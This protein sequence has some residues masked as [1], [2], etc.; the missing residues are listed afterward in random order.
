MKQLERADSSVDYIKLLAE[1]SRRAGVAAYTDA[2]IREFGDLV[3]SGIKESATS[4]HRIR[5]LRAEALFMAVVAGIGKVQLIK[6]EDTGDVCYNG[7]DIRVPDF[8]IV[9]ADSCQMFVEVKV[10]HVDDVLRSQFRLSDSYV[11]ALGRYCELAGCDLKIA[12]F[13]EELRLWTLNR[14]E[15]FNPGIA[16]EKRWEISLPKALATSEMASLGDVTVATLAPIRFRVILD[17]ARSETIPPGT[18]GEFNAT[19]SAVQLLSQERLL[20]GT[21]AQIAWKLIW[22]GK[23]DE[24]GDRPHYEEGRLARVDHLL[25]P[26]EWAE[27]SAPDMDPHPVGALSEMISN[28]YLRGATNT[29]HTTAKGDVLTPGYMGN[30][31]PDN[32]VS[33]K[34]DLPLYMFR[35]VPNFEFAEGVPD[36]PAGKAG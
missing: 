9:T 29:I 8:R 5:G 28:A 35:M 4:E 14:L 17:P 18:E 27:G 12:I 25:G 22:F 33:L 31:I 13:W 32:F 20:T 23:W 1:H 16:G 24:V 10:Q 7:D 30:F 2:A 3:C 26:P 34:L 19:V 15:S 36:V 21:S 11:Q 6:A